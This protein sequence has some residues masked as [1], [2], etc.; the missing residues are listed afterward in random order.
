[1]RILSD[2]VLSFNAA[3]DRA[4]RCETGHIRD[5]SWISDEIARD[6]GLDLAD[7]HLAAALW[8]AA[9][10]SFSLARWVGERKFGPH[11][12]TGKT[13]IGNIRLT[14]FFAGEHEVRIIDP[15]LVDFTDARGCRVERPYPFA[16]FE[17]RTLI[18]GKE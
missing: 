14:T 11:F 9:H 1:L 8:D 4:R 10:Q 15:D 16:P 7:N 17:S 6:E 12:V 3:H 2:S 5:G 13:P 18:R